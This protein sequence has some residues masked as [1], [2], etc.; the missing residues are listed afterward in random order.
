MT[1]HSVRQFLLC[2][3]MALLPAIG[4][5]AADFPVRPITIVVP[6][7]AGGGGDVLAR[8]FA[9][10]LKSRLGQPVLVDNKSGAGTLIGSE[11]VARAPADGYTLLLTTNTLL[12]API[13]NAAAA[14]FDPQKDF[15][16]VLPL[17]SI[18][19]IMVAHPRVPARDAAELIAYRNETR[20]RSVTARPVRAASP[21]WQA[22]CSRRAPVSR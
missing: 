19:I 6:Y 22:S 15:A 9:E 13:L 2:G 18:A 3:L 8:L 20:P 12:I 7:A 5:Q 1:N 16:P 11:F 14:K 17:A 4:T 10:K 21:I